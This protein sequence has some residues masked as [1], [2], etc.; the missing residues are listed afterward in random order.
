MMGALLVPKI[1]SSAAGIALIST[2]TFGY[3]GALAN[4]L[5]LPADVFSEKAIGTVWGIASMGSGIG[6][7]LFSLITGWLVEKYSFQSAFF[8]FGLLPVIS[9][10]LIWTLPK[11]SGLPEAEVAEQLAAD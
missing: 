2:A 3:S 7:M 9:S 1:T 8:L 6:G 4:L 5:A 11:A 10:I